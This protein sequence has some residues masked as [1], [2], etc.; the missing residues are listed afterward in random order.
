L[1]ISCGSGTYVRSLGRDLAEAVGS[2]AVMEQLTRTAVGRFTIEQS[3][4][5][6]QL[7]GDSLPRYLLDPLLTVADLP[8]VRIGRAEFA[9]LL[10]GQL[11][12]LEQPPA[13]AELAAVDSRGRLA[14]I[15]KPHGAGLWKP[16]PNFTLSL[17]E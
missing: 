4:Q 12:R 17:G 5:P 11:L 13:G 7:D 8:Q 2:G 9:R 6:E 15:L 16:A 1:D 10:R 14:A 3:V